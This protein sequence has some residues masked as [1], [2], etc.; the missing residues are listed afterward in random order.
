M[1]RLCISLLMVLAVSPAF[2]QTKKPG[3]NLPIDPLGLNA[4]VN[5]A[6]SGGA[7]DLVK[8][9]DAKLLPD[10]QYAL[11]LAT[12]T[13][14]DTT[15][16]CYQAWI[17]IIT[18]QQTAVKD[19]QGNPITMPDPHLITTFEQLVEIRNALQPQSAFMRACSPVANMVKMDVVAFMG[20]VISGGAGLA[21]MVPG[22]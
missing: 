9:L 13:K 21:T 8:A 10:L 16:A 6:A 2:A 1:R 5:T 18:T 3:L 20:I 14:N 22:L 7:V 11:L 19:A 15:A 12:A 4:K 17:D